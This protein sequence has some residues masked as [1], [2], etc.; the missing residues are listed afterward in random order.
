MRQEVAK[1]VAQQ[2]RP[3]SNIS[4]AD[5]LRNV[6]P[7]DESFYKYIPKM[8]FEE[9]SSKGNLV[10]IKKR[11]AQVGESTAPIAAHYDK[12]ISISIITEKA[13]LSSEKSKNVKK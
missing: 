10:R 13:D 12:N 5:L 7:S 4:I 8:F 6:N 1:G 11:N 2:Y 9:K 3:S